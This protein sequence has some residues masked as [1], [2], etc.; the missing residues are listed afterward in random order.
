MLHHKKE[1]VRFEPTND[2]AKPSGFWTHN[3]IVHPFLWD[4]EVSFESE[5]IVV[6]MHLNDR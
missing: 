5:L 2:D 1:K 3:L 4:K 6:C